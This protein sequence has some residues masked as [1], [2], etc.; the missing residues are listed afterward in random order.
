VKDIAQLMIGFDLSRWCVEGQI[1]FQTLLDIFSNAPEDVRSV[2]LTAMSRTPKTPE[3]RIDLTLP[4][5]KPEDLFQFCLSSKAS[6]RDFALRLIK[7]YP[8]RYAKPSEL[9][10]LMDSAD[11]R[12]CE[13]AV[14][15]LYQHFHQIQGTQPWAPYADSVSPSSSIAKKQITLIKQNPPEKIKAKDLTNQKY[16]GVGTPE[17]TLEPLVSSDIL[18]DFFK[19]TVFQIPHTHPLKADLHREDPVVKAWK[20]K[21]TLIKVLRD[22]ALED[23]GFAK[24]ISPLFTELLQSR[25]QSEQHACLTAI[26]Q[27]RTAYPELQLSF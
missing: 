3:E 18:V 6:V 22:I 7:D 17:K 23:Q 9:A 10:R 12:V 26:V 24:V 14:K 4:Q 2:F 16:L 21:V 25:G 27:L 5:F 11:R 1:T 13:T 8:E 19:R 20:N 15:I